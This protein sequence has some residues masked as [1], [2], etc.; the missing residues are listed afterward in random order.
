MEPTGTG[1]DES[2][3]ECRQRVAA[4]LQDLHRIHLALAEDSRALKRF[5]TEGNARVEL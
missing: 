2:A 5:T 3:R 1:S 4:H